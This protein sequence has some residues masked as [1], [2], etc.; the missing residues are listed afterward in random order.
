M[1]E[2]PDDLKPHVNPVYSPLLSI[3][4][5]SNENPIKEDEAAIFTS[6]NGVANAPTGA[7]RM[8][9]CVG[10]ATTKRASQR[11]WSAQMQ[12]RTADELVTALS[13]RPISRKLVHIRGTH[14]RGNVSDRLAS[15]GKCVRDSV[16]YDQVPQFLSATAEE[17]LLR[18][19]LAIVPLF[20]PRT[21]TQFAKQAP[22]ATSTRVV[23]LSDAVAEAARPIS[24]EVVAERPDAAAMYD[25]IRQAISAG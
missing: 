11:G 8:A 18:E 20:S 3:V 7:G 1:A 9:Y 22:R 2:M 15:A 21:A 13:A 25:A 16:V 6:S 24:V 19:E 14:T 4:P 10:K 17:V 23:A 5:L 12:G